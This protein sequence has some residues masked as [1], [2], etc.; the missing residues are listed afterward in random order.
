MQASCPHPGAPWS[1][2]DGSGLCCPERLL[3]SAHPMLATPPLGG[4]RVNKKG[5]SNNGNDSS[6]NNSRARGGVPG[7]KQPRQQPN[8]IRCGQ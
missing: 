5:T 1:V 2:Y 4:Q 3:P 8:M 6:N 7:H